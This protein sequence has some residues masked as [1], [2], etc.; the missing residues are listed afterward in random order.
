MHQCIDRCTHIH[1]YRWSTVIYSLCESLDAKNRR[2]YTLEYTHNM[3]E[4]R[5]RRVC[6]IDDPAFKTLCFLFLRQF[7]PQRLLS[8]IGIPLFV[9][10]A[11]PWMT[12]LF[13]SSCCRIPA[14]CSLVAHRSVGD[15]VKRQLCICPPE[16]R[17]KRVRSF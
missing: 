2:A 16:R 15:D 14:V 13:A 6:T 11:E 5:E 9:S 1:T 17:L 7:S 3:R 8:T 12:Q 4:I 10:F